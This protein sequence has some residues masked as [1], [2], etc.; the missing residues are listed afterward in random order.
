[1]KPGE[2]PY[3]LLTD[4]VTVNDAGLVGDVINENNRIVFTLE[5]YPLKD[6]T[7]RIKI[8]EKNPI[9]PRFEDPYALVK[10]IHGERYI[11]FHFYLHI[12][13]YICYYF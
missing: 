9:K 1:M 2:S 11:I 6:S 12:F 3:T 13:V 4:T 8:N 5:I 7:V 10:D